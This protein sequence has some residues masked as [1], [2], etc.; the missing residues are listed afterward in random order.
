MLNNIVINLGIVKRSA[1][2]VIKNRD[3]R[4]VKK[5]VVDITTHTRLC[6]I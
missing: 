1:E 2:G 6:S 4:R 3:N 5:L